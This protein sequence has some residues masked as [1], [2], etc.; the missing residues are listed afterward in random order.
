MP[1][2]LVK[3]EDTFFPASASRAMDSAEKGFFLGVFFI[4]FLF[5]PGGFPQRN[6]AVVLT[7]VILADLKDKGIQPLTHPADG[8]VLF[9]QIRTLVEVI[10]LGEYLGFALRRALF[11]R[12]KSNR[13]GITV[14]PW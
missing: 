3:K 7:L 2:L 6:Q 9:R 5:F 1:P 12:S 4:Q 11:W 8:P 14:I 13:I 10:R